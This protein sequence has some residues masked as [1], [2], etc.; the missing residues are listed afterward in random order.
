[1][2][3]ASIDVFHHSG[4]FKSP[5]VLVLRSI[6]YINIKCDLLGARTNVRSTFM[7]QSFKEPGPNFLFS[8]FCNL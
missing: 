2:S 4:L 8:F 7:I 1:M 6:Q 3:Y 5:V